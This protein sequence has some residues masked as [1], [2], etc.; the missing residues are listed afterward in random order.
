MGGGVVGSD[1]YVEIRG[2]AKWSERYR[3]GCV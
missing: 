2:W 3:W 1:Q